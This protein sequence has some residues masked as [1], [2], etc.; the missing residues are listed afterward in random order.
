MSREGAKKLERAYEIRELCSVYPK[1]PKAE[2]KEIIEIY[3]VW[4]EWNKNNGVK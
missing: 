2:K 1:T 4:G 3:E